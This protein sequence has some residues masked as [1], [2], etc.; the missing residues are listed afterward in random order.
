MIKCRSS[1]PCPIRVAAT[2][3]GRARSLRVSALDYTT[4]DGLFTIGREYR[5]YQ[6]GS[7]FHQRVLPR[8]LPRGLD[9]YWNFDFNYEIQFGIF[10]GSPTAPNATVA[11]LLPDGTGYAFKLQTDGTWIEAPNS[12]S[13]NAS[14]NL[15][16]EL[17]DALPADL[18]TL[19]DAATTWR[20]TDRNDTVW[21][22][23]TRTGPNG[24]HFLWG[25]PTS[26]VRRS[27]YSQTFSY[28]SDG[29]LDSI[30]DSLGRTAS[31]TWEKTNITTLA[32]PTAGR[33]P[34]PA[35]VS[36]INLPDGTSLSYGYEEARL[37][38][39]QYLYVSSKWNNTWGGG[40]SPGGA[41]SVV[42][43]LIPMARRLTKV[44]RFSANDDLLDS[45]TYLHEDERYVRNVT[46]IVDHRGERV[47][48]YAYDSAGR[49]TLTEGADGANAKA[50]EYSTS[51]SSRIREVT[52][53]YGKQETYIFAE[54]SYGQRD[55]RL[56]TI[57]SSA[58]EDTESS[59]STI[60]YGSDTYISSSTDAEGR[61]VTTTRDARGRP[62]S[63]TEASGTADART[64]TIA[65]HASFNLP[66]TIVGPRLTEE[67]N[68]DSQ[69]RL[70]SVTLTD[71][72]SQTAP[73]STNGQ[74]RT[75]TYTWDS[76]GR[77]LSEN[78]PLAAS[79]SDDDLTTYTYDV[80][81][82]LLTATNAMGHVTS[83]ADYDANGRP[84]SMTD[85]NGVETSFSYDLLGRVEAIVVQH[86]TNS[87]LN[88]TTS[89]EYDEVGNVTQLTLPSTTPLI[90]EY[91]AANRLTVMRSGAGE[92]WSYSYD[93][94]G[95]VERETVTRTDGSTSL[96]V[97]R[98]FDELG[99][100][101]RETLGTRSPAGW[102]YDKVD[103]VVG[104]TDP[105]GFTTTMSFDALDRV[106]STVA[107]DGGTAGSTYDEQGNAL[108][109]TDPV[110]VTTGFTYNGFGE[111]IE[112]VSPDRGTNTYWYD[113]AGRMTQSS[114]G[115]G[116]VINYEYDW[117]GRVTQ[118]TPVGRPASEIIE[119][120]YDSG[121]LSGSYEVGRLA[122]VVD[123]SGT[124]LFAYDHR[125]NQT[126]QQQAIGTSTTAQLSYE[127]DTADRITQINYPSG[128]QVRYG[129]DAEGR[130]ALV[131]TRENA[132][133][134]S[135]ELVASGHQYEP[136]GP[137]KSMAL[138]NGL[139][140]TNEWGSDGRLAAR[141]LYTTVGGTD[142][143]HLAYGR[144]AVGR[145][146]AI[147]DLVSPPNSI[148]YGYDEV[149]RLTMAVSDG[150]SGNA[151]TYAY[152]SGTNQLASLTD[153]NG[154]RT[155]TYDGRG[156]TLSESRPGG[157]AVTA[158]YDGYGRLASYDRT[159]I[160]AQTYSY[161]GVGDRVRVDKPTGTRHFVYDNDGRAIA[162]YGASATDVKAEFIWA[163]PP[164]A[165]S[166]SPFG[167]GDG[168][169]GYAPL[170][171]VTENGSS[172]LEL[173]WVHGNH[174]G[175]P[176]VTTNASG[177]VV[178]PGSDFLRPGFPGQSQVLSDLYYNR[179]RDYDPLTGR[180]I[181]ADP[182]GL[183]G[184]ANSYLYAFAD[185]INLI[186]PQGLAPEDWIYSQ[187]FM[188]IHM[189]GDALAAVNARNAGQSQCYD[190]W[191]VGAKIV[192][193]AIA[194]YTVF[195]LAKP[196]GRF[197]GPEGPVFGRRRLRQH[198][199]DKAGILNRWEKIRLGWSWNNKGWAGPRNYWGLH[200]GKYNTPGH[201]HA[202]PIPGPKG[203]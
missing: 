191:E 142:V 97:R 2:S 123:G 63:V 40:T 11:I 17:D 108:T 26:M 111:V 9:G 133:A 66:E 197:L 170:A 150:S 53:V 192:G 174:L 101:L 172:Q 45:V 141:R 112:E 33:L 175:V 88:A 67:R 21:T 5:S 29:G 78:G 129:Y 46:G 134:P 169:A 151:E 8:S 15:K 1:C 95:N 13:G 165:S 164:G 143:S 54:F 27:G 163:L 34:I 166:A 100:L 136:F 154:T 117:L 201:W 167:G 121:G 37:F 44:E 74:S 179:A 60:S 106:V 71:T 96:L 16:L 162:E 113:A 85:P 144:D 159:N 93:A 171:L 181:Q 157:I 186:D 146:G 32:N 48:T 49:V 109:F 178:T 58:T 107:P 92:R 83:Y 139:S 184:G 72:T 87:A 22:L 50:I 81:G 103:N 24:G 62:I 202:Q 86:P 70:E 185:P 61:V 194:S 23:E 168:V 25:W 188:G 148:I 84:G 125:G 52:N 198:I 31:F 55:Y 56:T 130:V 91:D 138:G 73:Y 102:G 6:V 180:Y 177:Q 89:M 153:T 90:M 122:K 127:Y 155:I 43:D 116:Q 68:Y 200:G 20:L 35:R 126:A 152:T 51:G 137:I 99:R 189:A 147:A 160:G 12:G 79:G 4:A 161:N 120:Y 140:V 182:I 18:G 131:E 57:A 3:F 118:M 98:Q 196:F 193:G 176:L 114:D 135:W 19:R 59:S 10:D 42:G 82:N 80:N 14:N 158:T 156:N 203:K 110:S 7:P 199:D 38:N 183:W 28:G 149:G 77:L 132:S 124:T 173:F 75:Y 128:R 187:Q 65:W 64:T 41:K 195:R 36:S 30:T 94:A 115:R 119:Y 76:N 190:I 47:S 145:I 39:S 105:N 69:G 104:A